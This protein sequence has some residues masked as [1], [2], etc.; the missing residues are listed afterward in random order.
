MKLV[1]WN[2]CKMNRKDQVFRPKEQKKDRGKKK[3]KEQREDK[4]KSF[5]QQK[6]SLKHSLTTNFLMQISDLF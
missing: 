1:I 2:L 4:L 5:S 3:G 6:V